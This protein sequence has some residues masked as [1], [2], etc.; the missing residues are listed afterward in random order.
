MINWCRPL[1]LRKYYKT[2]YDPPDG[3]FTGTKLVI[4]VTKPKQDNQ[5]V[6]SG[7]LRDNWCILGLY[8]HI[9]SILEYSVSLKHFVTLLHNFIN[10]PH[11]LS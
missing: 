11:S 2:L 5:E 1:S 3:S 4:L 7:C 8:I 9:T 10:L 6:S